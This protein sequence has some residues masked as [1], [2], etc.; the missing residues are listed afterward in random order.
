MINARNKKM[1]EIYKNVKTF[2]DL[3]KTNI[4]FLEGKNK[5]T[6]N[7]FGPINDDHKEN[8]QLLIELTKKG[9]LT[10]GG[11][12][13]LDQEN[14][15][16]RSYVEGYIK[17]ELYEKLKSF[18][19]DKNV[20]FVVSDYYGNLLYSN[21]KE[22]SINLTMY[23]NVKCTNLHNEGIFCETGSI[24][25]NNILQKCVYFSIASTEYG[26]EYVEHILFS[27]CL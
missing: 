16:Q 19:I 25:V 10:C 15:K 27:L 2:E 14:I 11:Q 6:F 5:I 8:I 9:F 4:D 3:L 21:F 20:Y 18:L 17:D 7:H 22:D 1:S 24:Y 13:P 26:K 23:N 12:S